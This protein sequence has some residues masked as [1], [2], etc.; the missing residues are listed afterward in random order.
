MKLRPYNSYKDSD[1]QW[2]GKIP[3]SWNVFKLKHVVNEFI[4]GGTPSSDNEKFWAEEGES[5][6]N[7]VAIGDM[8]DNEYIKETSKC[9][10]KQGLADKNLRILKKGTLLYSIFA[11]L[12]K[13]SI[14]DI[15]ATTNQA[16]LGLIANKK[17]NNNILK[18]YLKSLE[19]TIV[20]FSNAN[21]QNNLNSTIVKNIYITFSE[22]AKEQQKISSFL[23]KKLSEIHKTIE[24][25]KEL[26]ELLKEKR[27]ALI[28]HVVIKGLKPEAKLKDSR[29]QWIG[30]IPEGWNL[31]K[32]K[33]F[34]KI[35]T[36][37]TPSSGNEKYWDGDIIWVTPADLSARNK[38]IFDSKR[39][40]TKDGY[41]N[42]GTTF[43]SKE[44]IILATRAPIGYPTIVKEKLCFNQGCKAFEIKKDFISD[45]CYYYLIAYE[46]V[47]N[48]KGNATTFSELSTYDLA[49][50]PVLQP[51]KS[52]QSQIAKYLDNTTL[53]IDQTI[54]KIE[55]KINLLE[56]Y[57]KSL[58]HHVVTGKVDVREVAI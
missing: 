15:D 52:E 14:L 3:E 33:Q 35:F 9:I 37:S 19:E 4:S 50:F 34:S 10:T 46:E 53:K 23:D 56:E 45:Y 48:S 21:T 17:I 54:K 16:I 22:D 13:V 12:G 27:T 44:A 29:V 31:K 6:I 20:V 5:G 40:I 18:Y 39:K 41:I 38:Y 30:K 7:W 24:K 42:C 51:T 47:L 36:G 49:S 58:I 26:I 8:T 11:S 57:K 2:I 43:V 1:I 25:D 28:N 32:I 55:E